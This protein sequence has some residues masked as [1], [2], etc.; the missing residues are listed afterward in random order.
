M[1]LARTKALPLGLMDDPDKLKRASLP[2]NPYLSIPASEVDSPTSRSSQKLPRIQW[3]YSRMAINQQP[4]P[5]AF[6]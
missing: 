6:A 4:S 1:A 5:S 3:Y 2:A